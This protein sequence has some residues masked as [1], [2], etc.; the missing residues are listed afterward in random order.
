MILIT[1]DQAKAI[2]DTLSYYVAENA[3]N[4]KGQNKRNEALKIIRAFRLLLQNFRF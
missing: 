4:P 1:D 2:F 3:E